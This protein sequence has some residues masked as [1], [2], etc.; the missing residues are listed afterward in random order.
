MSG[1]NPE[2]SECTHNFKCT[3]CAI[4]GESSNLNDNHTAD[5]RRCPERLRKYGTARSYEKIVEKT[6]NPWRIV[7]PRKKNKPQTR[8]PKP[9][10]T[11]HEPG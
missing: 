10:D 1:E 8:T 2:V 7:V 11:H 5:S 4:P 9:K 3:N 6:E